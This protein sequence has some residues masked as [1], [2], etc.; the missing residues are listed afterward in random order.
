[1]SYPCFLSF[2]FPQVQRVKLLITLPCSWSIAI[3]CLN[4]PPIP[5][6]LRILGKENIL[7]VYSHSPGFKWKQSPRSQRD[8]GSN[9]SFFL[10][11]NE[12]VIWV[13]DL[14]SLRLHFLICKMRIIITTSQ[15]YCENWILE[16]LAQCLV[17]GKCSIHFCCYYQTTNG[18]RTLNLD[19]AIQARNIHYQ[20]I[21]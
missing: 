9:S 19:K 18:I 6:L 17:H 8:Q 21:M 20:Y 7:H 3:I 2:S 1:M 11:L 5:S 10:T 4:L 12:H 14:T 15:G 16:C 13:R